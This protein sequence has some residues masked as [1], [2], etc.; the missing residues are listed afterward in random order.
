MRDLTESHCDG[1]E[2]EIM[3]D[4]EPRLS[5]AEEAMGALEDRVVNRGLFISMLN[6]DEDSF[7]YKCFLPRI[8]NQDPEGFPNR[9]LDS[10]QACIQSKLSGAGFASPVDFLLKYKNCC[11][12]FS[13]A[14]WPHTCCLDVPTWPSSQP[15][16]FVHIRVLT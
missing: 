5:Q 4:A 14:S 12:V 11:A 8:S 16:S 6:T 3:G 13:L 7:F 10:P 2:A 9:I 15:C 1:E